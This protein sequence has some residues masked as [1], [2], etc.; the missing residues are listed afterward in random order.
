[1]ETRK[2]VW[3]WV[4]V[5]NFDKE[6]DWLN[7]MAMNGWTLDSVGFCVYHFV[8]TEPGEYNVRLEMR[9]YDPEYISFMQETGAEYIG[10]MMMWIYFRKR[11]DEGNFDLFSDLDSKI[12]HLNKIARVL[13]VIGCMNLFIGIF[14]SL[15]GLRLAWINL[16]CA[17]LLMYALGRIQGKEEAL[18]KERSLRE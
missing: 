14:N 4:W 2:T 8:R 7:A 10:R 1:M 9:K 18:K 15:S 3:K 11:A 16:C 17:T 12:N 6:E 13:T 5:W